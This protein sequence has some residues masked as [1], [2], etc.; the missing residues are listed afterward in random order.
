MGLVKAMTRRTQTG[1]GSQVDD[2]QLAAAARRGDESAFTALVERH[3]GGLHRAI[4]RILVDSTEAWDVVQ[5]TFLRSWQ[6]LDRY[7]PRWS[8][9]T[10][11][12]RIGTNL[13]IDLLRARSS[14]ERAHVAGAEHH[15]R[16]V[17]EGQGA[18][19]LAR[20]REVDAILAEVVTV[21]P[22]QQ[23]AA[24]V[25]RELEGQDTAAVADALGCSPT[26][27]RN[28]VFQARKILRQEILHRFPEYAPPAQRSPDAL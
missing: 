24:F 20:E 13:A 15:L 27:V 10:W 2:R 19:E 14:R 1:V 16:L 17:G 9:S 8:F 21:L 5:T 7:D 18:G 23:R 25:L 11:L 28:H 22:P 12:Y 6:S 3:A 26:T 4:A